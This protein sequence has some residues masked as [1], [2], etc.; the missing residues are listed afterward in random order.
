M[1]FSKSFYQ[2]LGLLI[3]IVL[4]VVL[5]VQPL[6]IA[7]SIDDWVNAQQ[8]E[9]KHPW[10]YDRADLLDW[11]TEFNLNLRINK[12]VGRTSA[13]LAIATLPK[14]ETEQ[15]P[16]AFAIKLFNALGIG[17]RETNNGVLLLVSKNDQ[18]IEIVTGKGLGEILPNGEVSDLIQQEIV[19]SF[20]S[21]Q[22]AM[23]IVQGVNAISQRLESRLPS[24][25]FPDWMPMIFL[26]IPWLIAIGGAV[27]ALFSTVQVMKLSFTPVQIPIPTQ[28]FN[29]QCVFIFST[30]SFLFISCF[31][32]Q[33]LPTQKRSHRRE[34]P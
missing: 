3:G 26:W 4:V 1:S 6:A 30:I 14:V 17:K 2:N 27:W 31:N 24:T 11:Q 7:Q 25:I 13:E 9:G 5:L 33:S 12:L 19:P 23:G 10:I 32:C 34:N 18:R 29:T 8:K 28:G 21:Q 16:R 22:Y 20:R 15:S